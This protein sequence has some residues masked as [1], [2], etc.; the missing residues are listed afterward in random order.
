MGAG[1]GRRSVRALSATHA[2][3]GLPH[4]TLSTPSLSAGGSP[5]DSLVH[6][7]VPHVHPRVRNRLHRHRL[8]RTPPSFLATRPSAICPEPLGPTTPHGLV[9][10][11][12]RKAIASES[13]GNAR[14]EPPV[15]PPD[16]LTCG[17]PS[18]LT[19]QGGPQ[20][21]Y[22]EAGQCVRNSLNIC[23]ILEDDCQLR[24]IENC[25]EDCRQRKAAFFGEPLPLSLSHSTQL[26]SRNR[27]V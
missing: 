1:G 10:A 4:S 12:C 16:Y 18:C 17:L 2:T 6:R 14:K 8:P 26:P 13:G 3:T 22:S 25:I 9:C 11:H 5:G 24:P 20:M 15:C 23:R 21:C 27:S 7:P 19:A